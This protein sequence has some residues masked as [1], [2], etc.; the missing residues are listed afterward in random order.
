MQEEEQQ[1]ENYVLYMVTEPGNNCPVYIGQTHNF[2]HRVSQ[3]KLPSVW[4][5]HPKNPF[6]KAMTLENRHKFV[7]KIVAQSS[8][9]E[10]IEKMEVAFIKEYKPVYNTSRG[11]RRVIYGY[12]YITEERIEF[13]G[14]SD[15]S[16]QTNQSGGNIQKVLQGHVNSLSN[17][18]FS[19]DEHVDW[20][21]LEDKARKH[22]SSKPR[23]VIGVNK[24]TGQEVSFQSVSEAAR[25]FKKPYGVGDI[26]KSCKNPNK[27]AYGYFWKY[28]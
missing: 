2:K 3:H 20:A 12:N 6:Y 25:F 7:Y 18:L 5:R 4:K 10:E 13:L 11:T 14:L 22:H 16:K 24:K 9:R 1:T 19:E 15:A 8:T 17:W 23:P 21:A 28:A 26:C 27:T